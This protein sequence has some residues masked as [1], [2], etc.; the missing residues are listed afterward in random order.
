MGS[1]LALGVFKLLNNDT[2][3]LGK[4]VAG[5]TQEQTVFGNEF[6]LVIP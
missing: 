6:D 2:K 4:N 3:C 1:R 5:K